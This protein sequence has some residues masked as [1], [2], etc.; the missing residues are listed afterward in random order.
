MMFAEIDKDRT[1]GKKKKKTFSGV[2]KT[3]SS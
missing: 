1:S 2:N 3:L